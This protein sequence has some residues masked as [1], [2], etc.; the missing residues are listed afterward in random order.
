MFQFL[1]G[2]VKTCI[3]TTFYQLVTAVSIPHRYCKNYSQGTGKKLGKVVSIPH[4]YC[5]NLERDPEE[6]REFGGFN[7]S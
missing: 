3:N 2:T 7:S 1:I 6:F 4:R 5:K